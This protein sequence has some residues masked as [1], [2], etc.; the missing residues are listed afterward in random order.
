MDITGKSTKKWD[1]ILI[2]TEDGSGD[3]YIELPL[4]FLIEVGWNEGDMI[5]CNC[6]D[7][8]VRL[9]KVNI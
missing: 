1:L 2:D 6:V 7:S 5:N 9:T 3:C 4:D 8:Q